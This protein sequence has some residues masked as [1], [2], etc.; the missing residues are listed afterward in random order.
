[1]V[2]D[3]QLPSLIDKDKVGESS[4]SNRNALPWDRIHAAPHETYFD[5]PNLLPWINEQHQARIKTDPDFV[6]LNEQARLMEEL[7]DQK[8]QSLRLATRQAEQA[9]QEARMLDMENR[10]RKAKNLPL[11]ESYADIRAKDEAEEKESEARADT[12]QIDPSNDPLLQEAGQVLADFIH[13]LQLQV[14]DEQGTK[15]ANF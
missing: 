3:I 4:D 15:V 6:F 13:Q 9:Q 10:R 1:V 12:T 5:I 7:K 8:T 11:Y 14:D 2:P